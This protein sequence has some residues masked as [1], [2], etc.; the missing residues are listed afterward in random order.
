MPR[1]V[2]MLS[3]LGQINDGL[4]LLR[5]YLPNHDADHVLNLAYKVACGGSAHELA[6]N[7]P[8]YHDFRGA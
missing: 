4:Q 5:V 8:G 1:L 2:V 3:L 7:L 6:D